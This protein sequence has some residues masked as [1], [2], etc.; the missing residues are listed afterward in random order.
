MPAGSLTLNGTTVV[1]G[2]STTSAAA[3]ATQIN[4]QTG[5]TGVT[6]NAQAAS[7]GVLAFTEVT[8]GSGDTYNLTVGG[9]SVASVGA[10]GSW[11]AAQ[12]DSELQSTDSGLSARN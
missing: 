3:L 5:T 7:S 10:N 2:S 4:L 6:A 12:L 9:V 8:T 11:T 1:T